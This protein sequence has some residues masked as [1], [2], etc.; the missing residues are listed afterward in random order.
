MLLR[1]FTS[2]AQPGRCYSGILPSDYGTTTTIEGR[3][4]EV[5]QEEIISSEMTENVNRCGRDSDGQIG[6]L[7]HLGLSMARS[8]GPSHPRHEINDSSCSMFGSG[9]F[10]CALN[11]HAWPARLASLSSGGQ[12]VHG[13]G[14]ED[15]NPQRGASKAV[16]MGDTTTVAVVVDTSPL[17]TD[18]TKEP[19]PDH[20]TAKA[21]TYCDCGFGG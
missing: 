11:Q 3:A 5:R 18:S 9:H 7:T 21:D 1:H 13:H 8:L 10:L 19:T 4:T 14:L 12:H 15:N 6:H 16:N 2:E 17:A 20:D